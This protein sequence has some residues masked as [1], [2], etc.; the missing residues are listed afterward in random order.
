MGEPEKKDKAAEGLGAVLGI[1]PQIAYDLLARVVP[2]LCFLLALSVYS[3]DLDAIIP[4]AKSLFG[5]T[6][7]LGVLSYVAGMV[8]SAFSGV[9]GVV[10]WSV[11]FAISKEIASIDS[12]CR[13][14]RSELLRFNREAAGRLEAVV[15]E[16]QEGAKVLIKVMG[17][18]A[19]YQSLATGLVLF[20]SLLW[21]LPPSKPIDF[22]HPFGG[23]AVATVVFLFLFF[24]SVV[25]RI[26]YLARLKYYHDK[27][28]LSSAK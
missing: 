3:P 21:I 24:A 20:F 23:V 12:G 13:D 5:N 22:A 27:C 28:Q 19:V 16:N 17:E 4:E 11:A 2:G 18:V 15:S 25:R 14:P 7:V 1:V 6:L 9:L 26:D 10:V 8:L